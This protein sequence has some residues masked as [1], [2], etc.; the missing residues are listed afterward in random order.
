MLAGA[1]VGVA[2]CPRSNAYLG[3]GRAPIAALAAAGVPVGLGSDS[4]ASGGSYDLRAEARATALLAAGEGQPAPSA[5]ELVRLATLGGAGVLGRDGEIGSLEPGKHADLVAL[6]PPPGM[7][8]GDPH[9]A[10]LDPGSRVETVIVGGETLV[11]GGVHRGLD[12]ERVLAR[13]REAR[14]GLC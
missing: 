8:G 9:L 6:R 13:A 7:L 14:E 1:G 4:P 12:R 11:E 3:C 2:H 10:L 5:A